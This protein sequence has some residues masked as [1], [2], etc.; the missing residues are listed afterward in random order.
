MKLCFKKEYDQSDGLYISF[1]HLIKQVKQKTQRMLK[2]WIKS[3]HVC[4]I[5]VGDFITQEY[6]WKVAHGHPHPPARGPR[7]PSSKPAAE[8]GVL[9]TSY[10]FGPSAASSSTFKDPC[11][12]TGPV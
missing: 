2:Y 9:V 11:D 3:S 1:Q 8:G 7:P 10:Y 12:Y 5:K 6:F 4:K